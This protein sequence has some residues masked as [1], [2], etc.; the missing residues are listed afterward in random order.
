MKAL[1]VQSEDAWKWLKNIEVSAWARYAMDHTCEIDLVVN[2]LSE[3]FNKMIPDVRSKPIRT[4]FEGIRMHLRSDSVTSP[5]KLGS[6]TVSG[7]CSSRKHIYINYSSH[8]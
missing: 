1:K 3:V 5:E 7:V 8:I 4:M 2:N 6:I